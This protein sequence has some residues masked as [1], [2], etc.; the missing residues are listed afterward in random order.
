MAHE[1]LKRRQSVMWGAGSFDEVAEFLGDVHE[2]VAEALLPADGERWLDLACGT[3]RIAELAAR[4][5]ATVVGIDLAPALIETAQ[6]RA[7]ERGLEIDYRVGDAERLDG[8]EDA[9]FDSVSSSFG[10][11]F[12]PDQVAAAGQLARVTRSG[13]R[14]ALANWAPDGSIG[15]FFRTMGPFQPAPPPS[16]PLLWG[17]EEH[18]RGLLGETFELSFER[19]TS[20]LEWES[21]AAM[22]DFMSTK[23]GPLV[24]LARSLDAARAA[25]LR[26]AVTGL[27]EQMRMGD[28]VVDVRD[29]LLITGTRR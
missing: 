13:G 10:I 4:A 12:A 18:V 21:G 3:G 6:A 28:K 20:P 17:D 23:F 24:T 25:E 19:R 1:E 27:G 5:G 11:M 15:T 8:V 9:A 14:I 29:Y 7:R 26:G 22:W 2:A 16:N